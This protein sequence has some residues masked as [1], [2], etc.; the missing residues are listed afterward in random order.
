MFPIFGHHSICQG[1]QV[2][3]GCRVMVVE[4][5]DLEIVSR[6]RSFQVNVCCLLV[7]RY[8]LGIVSPAVLYN[9]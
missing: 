6:Y 3:F 1:P 4:I 8:S 5:G 9:L 7:M 2:D